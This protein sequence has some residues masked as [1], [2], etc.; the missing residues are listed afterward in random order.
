MAS[1]GDELP[2]PQAISS[3]LTNGNP[4]P[5]PID[6]PDPH[7]VMGLANMAGTPVLAPGANDSLDSK[8]MP[9]DTLPVTSEPALGGALEDDDKDSSKISA[10]ARLDFDSYTFFVQTLQVLLGRK[11]NDEILNGAQHSVDVH[12]S[13]KKAISRRHAKIFYNFGTQR[14]ELSIMGRNGAFVD[15]LFIEKGM[16]IPLVDGTKIQI[17]DIP[18]C[19][20]LPSLEPS[21]L[22]DASIS[23][24]PFNPSDAISLRSSLYSHSVSPPKRTKSR[25][26][27]KSAT[28]VSTTIPGRNGTKRLSDARRQSLATATNDEINTILTE[29]G[30]ASIEDIDEQDPSYVDAQIKAI[31]GDSQNTHE[32]AIADDEDEE[33]DYD[34]EA[35]TLAEFNEGEEDELDK[36]VKQHNLEQGVELDEKILARDDKQ[37][38]MDINAI[39][40]ELGN[41]APLINSGNQELVKEREEKKRQLEQEK[42]SKQEFQRARNSIINNAMG[43]NSNQ[44][45]TNSNG[46]RLGPLMGKPAVPR[47]GKPASIQPPASRLYG[48]PISGSGPSSLVTPSPGN[49]SPF[50]PYSRPPA[51][52]LLV[53]IQTVKQ[54]PLETPNSTVDKITVF[55]EYKPAPIH[56]IKVVGTIPMVPKIPSDKKDSGVPKRPSK[57]AYPL[58]EIPEPYRT[59]PTLSFPVML[60]NVLKIKNAVQGLSLS[61]IY[62]A[63]KEVYP[64]YKYCPD[65]W[66]SGVVH[67]VKFNKIF[68]SLL[69]GEDGSGKWIIDETFIEEKE[70]ARKK[71][72]DI[73]SQRAKE[74]AIKA[75]EL[76]QKQR[77]EMQ[78][79]ISHNI[80]GRDYG[81]PYGSPMNS[82]SPLLAQ[83]QKAGS[84]YSAGTSPSPSGQPNVLQST[85]G[86]KPKTIAELASEIR[87][88]KPNHDS[89]SNISPS[90]IKAQLAA[91]RSQYSNSPEN[92]L[93]EEATESP[94]PNSPSMNQDTKKSLSYLQKELFNLYKA[95]KLSYNTATTTEIITKA[96]ATTIA[97]VNVIGSKAGVKDNA[98][99]FLVERAPQQV[100]KILDIALTKSIKEK[101]GILTSRS[102][103][104]GTTPGTSQISSPK[105]LGP[106]VKESTPIS[107]IVKEANKKFG[108]PEELKPS[109]TKPLTKPPQFKPDNKRPHEGE[110]EG[111]NKVPKP[112][113]PS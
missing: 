84:S 15:D 60:M 46:Q 48:K 113:P 72:Q 99:G 73:A 78:Q 36:L 54:R 92:E 56:L 63:I 97:Q 68:K 8:S 40:R 43:I 87:R 28:K 67:N 107:S 20:I 55:S 83:M 91:N 49:Y 76:K 52:E 103:S 94:R 32:S 25:T 106:D 39:D 80:V 42:K 85:N 109:Y 47:M 4:F 24:K 16:T 100:S 14:F 45:G 75:E 12:L 74:A 34:V 86:Q 33:D 50:N 88:V 89:S 6:S 69:S 82:Q 81:S 93:V 44:F 51:P 98:L 41:L 2:Y 9:K 77:M 11:S 110:G 5:V 96:L 66:Q 102:N 71:Q 79:S 57:S 10:Y 70:K 21:Q 95:R 64:Y 108:K 17:G 101:Q 30:V 13:S 105:K 35:G 90:N 29:L 104:R 23:T 22:K 26:N 27:T 31:L 62:E 61:E 1:L 112:S 38:E 111:S 59:K 3:N 58:N 65:G 18:F 53:P 19:F 7:D 37:I